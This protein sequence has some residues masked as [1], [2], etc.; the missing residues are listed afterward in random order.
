MG[1]SKTYLQGLKS[2][3]FR[4]PLDLQA[5]QTLQQL[6]GL[7][8]VVRNLL[9]PVAEQVFY[10]DNISSSIQVSD[11]Q[12]PEIHD[13]VVE[14]CRI[15]DLEVPQI[16]IR[17]N[18]VP[19]AYTFAMRGRKPFIVLHT[20]IIDLLTPEEIQAVIAHELGHLKCD[21]GVYLTLANLIMLAAD[22]LLPFGG[23]VTQSLQ[24]QM[25]Q[26]V[27]CAEFTC[28]RAALLV[29]QDARVVA[30][31]LMKLTGGSLQLAQRLNLD[32]FLEQARSYDTITQTEIGRVLKEA[33]VSPLTHPLPVLR[34][35]EIDQWARSTDYHHI[36]RRSPLNEEEDAATPAPSP[37]GGWRNW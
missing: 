11:R 20:S 24:A 33:Q 37:A 23:L 9:G 30:S 16:Y 34:A 2:S 15:L 22:Q 13:L 12:L 27:R 10:L 4:H 5:T 7:D 14:A 17:Q 35:R 26:W 21:H 32:A 1:F 19:N 6:P 3:H 28:D 29:A 31:V 8:L 18:P 25:M 36:M